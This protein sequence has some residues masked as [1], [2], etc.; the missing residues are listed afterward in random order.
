MAY[1]GTQLPYHT[2]APDFVEVCVDAAKAGGVLI[3]N[4]PVTPTMERMVIFCLITATPWPPGMVRIVLTPRGRR[5]IMG[6]LTGEEG[7]L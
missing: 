5:W 1:T 2:E 3:L 7:V 4:G 6:E